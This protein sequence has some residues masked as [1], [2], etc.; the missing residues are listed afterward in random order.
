MSQ[1][2]QATD[3]QM[4][5]A[6]WGALTDA[7]RAGMTDAQWA[8]LP[9]EEKVKQRA[10]QRARFPRSEV[11]AAQTGPTDGRCYTCLPYGRVV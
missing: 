5:E 9:E 6:Q 7:Q 10:A 2:V 4:T 8:A 11:S 1:T 3:P